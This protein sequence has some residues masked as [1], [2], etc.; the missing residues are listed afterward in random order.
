MDVIVPSLMTFVLVASIWLLYLCRKLAKISDYP[1]GAI[2]LY[3]VLSNE[4][5]IRILPKNLHYYPKTDEQRRLHNKIIN[6][7][8]RVFELFFLFAISA[9][10]FRGIIG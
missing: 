9:I 2:F 10:V 6:H 4:R 5:L 7:Y 1:G 3:C 8:N